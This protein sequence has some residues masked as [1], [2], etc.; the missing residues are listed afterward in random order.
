MSNGAVALKV[1]GAAAVVTTVWCSWGYWLH[2]KVMDAA[3]EHERKLAAELRMGEKARQQLFAFDRA[4][5]N[6][7]KYFES[8]DTAQM[9]MGAKA[10]T[11]LD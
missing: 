10:S 6:N 9:R 4:H 2:N 7:Q 11:R 1:C 8:Q 5:P 3:N